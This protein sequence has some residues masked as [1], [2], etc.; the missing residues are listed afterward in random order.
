MLNVQTSY[1]LATIEPRGHA[2]TFIDKLGRW[3]GMTFGFILGIAAATVG[4]MAYN[5]I[6]GLLRVNHFR[7]SLHNN[8]IDEIANLM[9][10]D[11]AT[12]TN[13]MK[14]GVP[15]EISEYLALQYMP[16]LYAHHMDY[17]YT[18]LRTG[19]VTNFNALRKSTRFMT[20]NLAHRNLSGLDLRGADFSGSELTGTDF[21]D[22]NLADA[23]F[24]LA[25]MPRAN[26]RNAEVSR[27]SFENAVLSSAILTRIHG[28]GTVFDKAVLVDASMTQLND[29][30]VAS[31]AGAELAQANLFASK[32][33]FADFDGADFTL[34][35]AVASDFGDVESMRDVNLTGANLT[36]ARIEPEKIERAW[37]VNTDGL[38][39]GVA[40][41]LRRRGGVARPE[42]VLEMVDSR[43]IA[44]FRA[45]IEEDNSIRPQDRESVLL[46]MLQEYY[47]N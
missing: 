47:L 43:I 12:A 46:T 3:E 25:E 10:E 29:L 17:A 37:F 45:Q 13:A 20:Y 35:S 11:L 27:A 18:L 19:E 7:R 15:L 28:E 16:R 33:P 39:S 30:T 2:M 40:A 21:S 36:N 22:C 5:E 38:Q 1:R 32:F 23:S 4:S 14:D 44:G 9:E 42:D 41:A 24:Q 6:N 8:Q 31:F 34:A 26:L